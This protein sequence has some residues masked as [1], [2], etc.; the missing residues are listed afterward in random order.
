ME[1]ENHSTRVSDK[2]FEAIKEQLGA[3]G[4]EVLDKLTLRD[5]EVDVRQLSEKEHWQIQY[6]FMNDQLNA[7]NLMIQ[8]LLDMNLILLESLSES[9]KKKVI[10]KLDGIKKG[11]K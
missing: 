5:G 8:T 11:K 7:Y 2:D 10:D 9:K 1:I 3:K 6:R 4:N